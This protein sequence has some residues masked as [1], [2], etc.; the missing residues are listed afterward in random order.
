MDD[1]SRETPLVPASARGVFSPER[2]PLAEAYARSLAT[3]GVERGLIGPRE[4]PRLWER[5]LLNCAV[6]TDAVAEGVSVADVGSGAGLPGI[7][8]AIRRPDLRLTLIE[9]LLR[10]AT[11]LD[12]VAAEL[13]L[14]NVTVVRARAE[15]AS[16]G[17]G[18][19]VVTSRAVAAL[20]KLARWC[21]PLVAVGGQMLAMKGE[22]ASDEIVEARKALRRWSSGDA[23]V[24]TVGADV[25]SPQTTLVRVVRTK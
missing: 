2:L 20:D 21:M 19:D 9:P 12:E 4:V 16:A 10:R 25:V 11:Y 3:A 22:R 15:D 6:V 1:V 17:D 13:G 24:V 8:M 23:E 18:F 14:E 7:V 5:H